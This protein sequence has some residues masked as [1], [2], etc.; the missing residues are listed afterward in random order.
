M[1]HHCP[2]LNNCVGWRNYPYFVRLLFY[3]WAGCLF[4][5]AVG[6]RPFLRALSTPPADGAEAAARRALLS[7]HSRVMLSVILCAAIGAAVAA[8]LAWHVYLVSTNQSSI[9][10]LGNRAHA[11]RLQLRGQ[12]R[13]NPHDRGCAR[14]WRAVFGDGHPALWLLPRLRL[15]PPA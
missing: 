11:S 5:I 1:D 6:A 10:F 14:N 8:L 7:P 12:V 15:P 4:M 13:R 3:V 2:W 9:E